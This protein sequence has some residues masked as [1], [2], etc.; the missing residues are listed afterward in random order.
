MKKLK[1]IL[2][3]CVMAAAFVSLS[4]ESHEPEP[5]PEPEPVVDDESVVKLLYWNLQCGM[6][7]DQANN[8]DNFVA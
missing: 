2:P 1:V 6:W 5:V 7:A 8:Y 3:L 4:C